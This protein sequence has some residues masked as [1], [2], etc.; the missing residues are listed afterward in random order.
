MQLT[1][2]RY[3]TLKKKSGFLQGVRWE[4]G[5]EKEKDFYFS[6]QAFIYD[7]TIILCLWISFIK[8]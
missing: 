8:K 3:H 2:R 6:L 5:K 1:N 7:L 4:K